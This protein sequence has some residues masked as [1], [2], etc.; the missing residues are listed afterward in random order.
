MYAS[1]AALK[2]SIAGID[3]LNNDFAGYALTA[4]AATDENEPGLW[5]EDNLKRNQDEL[6]TWLT[7]DD[8]L[9]DIKEGFAQWADVKLEDIFPSDFAKKLLEQ[10]AEHI[11]KAN[12]FIPLKY[13]VKRELEFW[14]WWLTIAIAQAWELA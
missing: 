11:R 9:T 1:Y 12:A 3:S 5:V 6:N 13:D 7:S 10:E 8:D 2:A 4:Y 14:Q